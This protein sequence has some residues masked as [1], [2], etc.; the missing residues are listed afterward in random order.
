MKKYFTIND[1]EK[2]TIT[3]TKDLYK[4][5][6]NPEQVNIYSAFDYNNEVFTKAEGLY[7]YT[8]SGKKIIDF[9]GGLGV[10]NH[11]HNHP[12][13]IDA[14]IKFQNELKIEVNKLNLS[15]YVAALGHNISNVLDGKL[16]K[17][18]F[19]NS[20]AEANEGAIK[21]AYASYKNKR[22]YIISSDDSFHG[23]LIA[24][25]TI[26]GSL[27][28]Y[29]FP[30]MENTKFFKYNDFESLVNTVKSV[31]KNNKCNVYAI[32]L[33]PFI[34]QRIFGYDKDFIKNT[35]NLC[36]EYNIRLIF[37][38]VYTGWGKTGNIFSFQRYN[39]YYPDILTF[40]KSFGGG[41]SSISGFVTKDDV[42][43]KAFGN[44]K[45]ALMHTSTYN[46]FGEECATAIEAI[47]ILLEDKLVDRGKDIHLLISKSLKE[48]KIKY[49]NIINEIRG[50]GAINGISFISPLDIFSKIA[51]MIPLEFVSDKKE[52]LE[53]LTV[54]SI[55]NH[56]YKEHNILSTVTLNPGDPLL[57]IS[58]SLVASD[59]DILYF[60]DSLDNTLSIGLSSL[61]FS[62]V[63][64]NIYKLFK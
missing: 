5:Y 57:S 10:L 38:E 19:V 32:I 36:N 24:T 11:G 46:G 8:E 43:K 44:K 64:S 56:I 52:F 12:K 26:T 59:E 21:T 50:M 25:G 45:T 31:D 37:D 16:N 49:P 61:I 13:I 14:R 4:K 60:M 22:E 58:P 48:L 62:F 29:D 15:P 20:G 53:K 40:S 39:D 23:K 30:K 47:N 7:I 18:Y 42:F 6:I 1:I 28:H 35:R 34:A 17:S 27:K 33:E 41:K 55:I 9:T 3:E 51:D 63:K 54:A 2:L